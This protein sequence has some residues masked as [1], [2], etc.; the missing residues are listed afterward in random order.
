MIMD[1]VKNKDE[2]Q[3]WKLFSIFHSGI[4]K[5]YDGAELTGGSFGM[6]FLVDYSYFKVN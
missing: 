6:I 2:A 1:V 3:R 4:V 5:W